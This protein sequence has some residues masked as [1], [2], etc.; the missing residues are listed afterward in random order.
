MRAYVRLRGPDGSSHELVHGDLVGRLRTAAMPLDDSR[1]SEAHA[2]VS[3]REQE[4]RL[5]AL[6]GGLAVDGEP[7]NEVPLS[8]GLVILLAR[9]LSVEVEDVVLPESVLG[10]EGPGL[11]RQMLPGVASVVLPLRLVRGHV[12]GAAA[13]IWNTGD[14]WRLRIGEA[15]PRTLV[16]G[17]SFVVSE[18]CLSA[19]AVPLQAAGL[20]PTR[21]H[22]G[23]DAPLHLVAN[24]DTVHIQ[25]AGQ[26]P[27]VIG[28][29]P[30]RIISE[31]VALG[32]PVPWTLL[33]GQ[34]WPKEPDP[35]VVRSRLDVN[36]SRLRRKL[37]EARIRTD[38][39]HTDGAGQ[40]ELL[41]YPHDTA[42]D[43]T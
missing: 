12:E 42:E 21:R 39:V 9:G 18:L 17:D 22:G 33:A 19:V 38:L 8:P 43:R 25:R 4:L 32:G 15:P 28:G 35:D 10:L 26:T 1:V 11:P 14:V 2:M 37:R 31:L 6:R 23:V 7:R 34:I 5:V 27:V 41:L 20:S 13:V 29:V 3:L 40:V 24:L 16:A 30:A 36:L